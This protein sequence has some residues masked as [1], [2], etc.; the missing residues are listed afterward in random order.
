MTGLVACKTLGRR[1]TVSNPA[2][3]ADVP[4]MGKRLKMFND[5]TVLVMG[6]GIINGI[7][8]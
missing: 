7:V 3:V 2:I 6:I 4:L 8:A 5:I 1:M